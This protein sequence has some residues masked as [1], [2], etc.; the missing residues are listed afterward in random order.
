[1]NKI[2]TGFIATLLSCLL[3]F[4]FVGCS[5]K[6]D[7][8]LRGGFDLGDCDLA[9]T[10]QVGFTSEYSKIKIGSEV[11]IKLF[12]G[13]VGSY[14]SYTPAPENV[15]ANVTMWSKVYGGNFKSA[16][17]IDAPDSPKKELLIK[18][19]ND[20]VN[21]SY[22]W[23]SDDEQT[24]GVETIIVFSD[25]FVGNAG[26]I[27]WTVNTCI[28]FPGDSSREDIT[29]VGSVSLYYIKKGED[30]VLFGSFYDFFNY[31]R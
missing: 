24:G 31:K 16:S 2:L 20:F 4:A 11:E 14:D 27:G 22:K 19:F 23:V 13:H 8:G 10:I 3:L 18:E 9:P 28:S 7:L 30:I 26:T 1:M 21:N 6:E 5:E 29:E 12:Y 25:W 17:W 15:S